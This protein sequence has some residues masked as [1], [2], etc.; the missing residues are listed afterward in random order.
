MVAAAFRDEEMRTGALISLLIALHFAI[1]RLH[2][3]W[4]Y[5]KNMAV[6]PAGV[7]GYSQYH[8]CLYELVKQ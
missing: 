8:G 7:V 6:T 1:K 2:T 3:H 5:K 4:W